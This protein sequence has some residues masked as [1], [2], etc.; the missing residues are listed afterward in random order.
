MT[1]CDVTQVLTHLCAQQPLYTL[2]CRM[3]W[4]LL[5]GIKNHRPKNRSPVFF[6]DLFTSKV[7]E[8]WY[9]LCCGAKR[10]SMASFKRS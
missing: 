1:V 4:A 7:T 8:A 3:D 6:E 5:I 9:R 10:S 2:T